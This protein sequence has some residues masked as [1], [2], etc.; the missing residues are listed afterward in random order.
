MKQLIVAADDF[1]LTKSINKGIVKAYRDGI[2]TSL[3]IIPTGDAF[4]DAVKLL[5]DIKLE[6][7][8]AHLSLTETPLLTKPAEFYKNHNEFFFKFISGKIKRDEIYNE[9]KNQLDKIKKTGVKIMN[10]SSHEHI[11]MIPAILKI[12]VRLAKEYDIPYIRCT[13]RDRII[14]PVTLK[15]I[16]KK[17]ILLCFGGVDEKILKS[18]NIKGADNLFG[19]LDSGYINE[20]VLVNIL[21][22]LKEG[23]TEL[24]LHPGFLGPQILNK[25][26]FH[27][28]CEEE[29]SAITSPRIKKIIKEEGIQL[30]AKQNGA[31]GGS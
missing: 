23:T 12:F 7:V 19:F 16:Y 10:L 27:I 22:S 11:H 6:E 26:R 20:K 24:I 1:G 3:N 18:A 21:R 15:K 2:V 14:K 4:E 30:L 5:K 31:E 29:L 28:K 25:Y 9:L 17:M 13:Y 8:G